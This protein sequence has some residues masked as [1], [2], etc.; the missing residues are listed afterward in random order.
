MPGVGLQKVVM[1]MGHQGR[2]GVMAAL[3]VELGM[4]QVPTPAVLLEPSF[5]P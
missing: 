1:C 4:A 5:K 3:G 2:A